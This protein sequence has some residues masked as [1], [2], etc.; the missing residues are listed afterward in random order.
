MADPIFGR[1]VGFY[2]FTLPVYQ[3]ITG[4]LM[5]LS[6]ILLIASIVHAVIST[7][8]EPPAIDED[9]NAPR[10][11]SHRSYTAVSL[12]FGILLLII[13]ISTMLSRYKSLW[14]DHAS[15]SGVTY[16]EANYLLPGLTFVAVA[17][18]LAA[19]LLILNAFTQKVL[20]LLLVGLA[21]PIIV[22]V[23]A[24]LIIPG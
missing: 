22:Y 3:L 20:R 6:T 8:L 4:W 7:V 16:T 15:F 19:A 2:L 14:T 12:A 11:L 17:L 24:A 5:M 13:A 10:G 23:I 1:S 18:V 9:P 21:A